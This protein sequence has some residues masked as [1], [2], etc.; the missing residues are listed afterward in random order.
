MFK[1]NLQMMCCSLVCFPCAGSPVEPDPWKHC[2]GLNWQAV[3]G[4]YPCTTAVGPEHQ[5]SYLTHSVLLIVMRGPS[6]LRKELSLM[7]YA[8][9][10]LRLPLQPLSLLLKSALNKVIQYWVFV[11][12]MGTSKNI[13]KKSK[14]KCMQHRDGNHYNNV[15]QGFIGLWCKQF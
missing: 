6:N 3:A 10:L 2:S 14:V 8:E 9:Y 7:I 1:E 12:K 11:D 15:E 13:R 5:S 4:Y